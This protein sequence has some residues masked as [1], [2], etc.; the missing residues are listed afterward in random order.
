MTPGAKD[1]IQQLADRDY[2]YG[3]VTDIDADTAPPGLDEDIV[4][5]ISA[6][7]N[8]PSWLLEW[9]LK[10]YRH[11]RTMTEPTWAKVSYPPIDYDAIIYCAAPK[12]KADGPTVRGRKLASLPRHFCSM[13]VAG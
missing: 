5:F 9:R 2:E 11:W 10:A 12:S 1:E 13:Q 7:K 3:F 8:E 6:K 4:R